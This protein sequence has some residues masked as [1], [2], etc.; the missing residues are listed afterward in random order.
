MRLQHKIAVIT[1]GASGIGAATASRFAKEGARVAVLDLQMEKARE[2]AAECGPDAMAL[3][4]DVCDGAGVTSAMT[5]IA[6]RFGRIDVLINNA[7]IPGRQPID[8]LDEATWTRVLDVSLKG[9]YLCS[10]A[11]LPFMTE[12]GGSIVHLSS[13]AG[14]TGMRNRPAYSAA[15]AGLVALAKNMA[16]DYASRGIRVNCVCPGF[17]Q[18]PLVAAIAKDPERWKRMESL[19]PLGRLGTPED[20]ANALLFLASDE[21]SWITGTCLVVDGG[22]SAG[23]AA[24]V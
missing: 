9:A 6:E 7:G 4:A 22:F 15:K 3:E 14:I 5:Q 11:A 19:H 18:T 21:A 1:G 2:V 17:T 8:Q 16:L 20:I 13:V 10:K 12:R 23:P 24:D